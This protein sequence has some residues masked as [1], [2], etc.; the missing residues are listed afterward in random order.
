M[1]ASLNGV[2]AAAHGEARREGRVD[3][4]E[5]YVRFLGRFAKARD[6]PMRYWKTRSSTSCYTSVLRTSRHDRSAP[7][8]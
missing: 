6:L 2:I 3:A 5:L 8:P 4:A 1:Q 7:S